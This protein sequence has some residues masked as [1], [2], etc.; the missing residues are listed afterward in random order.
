[1]DIPGIVEYGNLNKSAANILYVP[2]YAPQAN[3]QFQR[4]DEVFKQKITKYLKEINTTLR[5]QDILDIKIHRYFY[6]QPICQ[7]NYLNSLPNAKTEI[8]NLWI[9]DTSYYY[10]EDRGISESIGF[11]R[12]M[13]RKA[14]E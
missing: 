5:D 9:A 14:L 2:Y 3:D 13:A 8:Q 7:P 1:M 4:G 10:P 12:N 11:G 6:A